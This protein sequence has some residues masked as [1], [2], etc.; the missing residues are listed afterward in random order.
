MALLKLLT[1][2]IV[3]IL[4]LLLLGLALVWR[5]RREHLSRTGFWT[6]LTG[7]ALLLAL[8]LDPVASLLAYSLEYR[9]TRPSDDVLESLDLVVVLGGGQNLPGGLR[10]ESELKGASYAR[11]YRGVKAFQRSHASH[12]AFCGGCCRPGTPSSAEVMKAVALEMGVAKNRILVESKSHTTL[13]NAVRLAEILPAGRG[14]RIGL[15]TSASHML[16]SE[17]V[18]KKQFPQETIVPIPADYV[19]DSLAIEVKMFIPSARDFQNS[20]TAI[21]EWIGVLWYSLHHR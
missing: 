9:Y 4:L 15:V 21:H 17:R 18:F 20:T 1:T 6:V 13:E 8:S 16:R 11:V 14:R 3:W 12:L 7:T 2:P 10:V 19:Y 5:K